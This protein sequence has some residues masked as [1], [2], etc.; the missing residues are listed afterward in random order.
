[1]RIYVGYALHEEAIDHYQATSEAIDELRS[2]I[3]FMAM[4]NLTPTNLA[5][6]LN[7][8]PFALRDH[9]LANKMRTTTTLSV[10]VGFGE[11]A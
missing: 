8:I 1:M 6:K 10:D 11:K 7:K 5:S 3:D 4:E 9:R 2:E